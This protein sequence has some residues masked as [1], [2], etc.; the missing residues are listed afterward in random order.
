M[1]G[2]TGGCGGMEVWLAALAQALE[3]LMGGLEEAR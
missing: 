3:A 2:S 1:E